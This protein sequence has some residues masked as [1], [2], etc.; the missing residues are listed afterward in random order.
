MDST[1]VV[2]L[3]WGCLLPLQ[4]NGPRHNNGAPINS[5][6]TLAQHDPQSINPPI[7][8]RSKTTSST[9]SCAFND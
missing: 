1:Q 7:V 8:P 3:C 6:Q 5:A 2:P 4:I 9:L